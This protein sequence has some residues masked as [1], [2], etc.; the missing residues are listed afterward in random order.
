MPNIKT[1]EKQMRKV[2]LLALLIAGLSTAAVAEGAATATDA[3][4]FAIGVA[5]DYGFGLSMQFNN[6]IDVSVGHAGAGADFIIYRYNFMPESKFF[7][8]KPMNFYVGA[9]GGYIWDDSFAGMKRGGIVRAPIGADWQFHRKWAVHLSASPA[10]NFQQEQTKNGVVSVKR[11]T[12]FVVI[13]TIG[14]R[15]LF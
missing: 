12:E 11:G 8:T 7:S 2:L 5:E 13:G 15:Y 14:I 4:G 3:R 10:L 9:G 1:E 6:R